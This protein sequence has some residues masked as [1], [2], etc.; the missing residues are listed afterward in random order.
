MP[1]LEEIA[2]T[3]NWSITTY[4]ISECYTV[5]VMVDFGTPERSQNCLDWN[6]K[7]IDEIPKDHYDLVVFSNRTWAK[8]PGK[9]RAQTWT[10][11][12]AAYTRV[13]TKWADAGTPTL[14]LH[15]T[16]YATELKNVP[17][18]VAAHLDDLSACDGTRAREQKDPLADAAARMSN[19]DVKML[20]LTDR[21][22][23]GETCY[24]VLGGVIV[25]FDRGHMS[26]TFAKSLT[27]D[28]KKAALSVMAARSGAK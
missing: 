11:A 19:P 20:D 12:G 27:P 16:P 2:K 24:S 23:S 8:M 6:K 5:D 26:A 17:D 21:I 7:V 22:C 14:V 18:C 9:T 1:A 13:L 4:L 15:D 28:I 10:A 3:E 25:Y